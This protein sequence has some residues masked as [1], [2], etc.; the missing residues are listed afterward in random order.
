[1]DVHRRRA[2]CISRIGDIFLCR[3]D[4]VRAKEMWETA[5][6]LFVRSSRAKDVTAVD[7]RLAQL[8]DKEPAAL[9]N[10]TGISLAPEQRMKLRKLSVNQ[11]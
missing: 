11:L 9:S 4:L 2:D 10:P 1:M 6:P 3:G 8:E 5:R 7:S